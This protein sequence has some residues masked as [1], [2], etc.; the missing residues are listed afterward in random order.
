[1]KYVKMKYV[2][3]Q[4]MKMKYV[5]MKYVKMKYVKMKYVRRVEN[6]AFIRDTSRSVWRI[7]TRK[8][9]CETNGVLQCVAVSCRKWETLRSYV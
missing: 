8:A 7:H 2:K 9:V 1:M 6:E 3:M 5:K 4:Y